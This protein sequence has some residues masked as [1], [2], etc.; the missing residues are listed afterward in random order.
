MQTSQ[1]GINL[2]TSFE[3]CSTKSYWDKYGKVW[4]IGYGH[5][6]PDVFEGQIISKQEAENLLKNNL[7]RFESYVNNKSYVP[8]VI[9]QNQFDALVSFSYNCGQGNLKKLVANRTLPQ[10]AEEIT[11][12]NKSKWVYLKG[13]ARRREAEK[14]LFLS[15]DIEINQVP[16]N[17]ETK[18]VDNLSNI[19]IWEFIFHSDSKLEW[20]SKGSH[21]LLG[22]YNHNGVLDLYYI[23]TCCPEFIEVHILEG[24][25]NFKCFLLQTKTK[26]RVEEADLDFCLGDYNHDGYLDLFYIKKNKTGTN[27]TEVHILSGKSN[28]QDFLLQTKTILNEVNNNF[29]FCVGDYNNDGNLDLFCIS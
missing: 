14:K 27:S 16:S 4:T 3:G 19:P 9:N 20:T 11:Q 10:I 8:H 28:F 7:K 5:T 6:G 1:K 29:K 15:G 2:I 13:L 18:K 12:Y 23:T 25:N 26:L 17:Y 24:S 22:D 21:F